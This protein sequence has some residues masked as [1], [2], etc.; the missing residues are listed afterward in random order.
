MFEKLEKLCIKL[1]G[2]CNFNC[3]Y[4]HQPLLEKIHG[5][6]NEFE[7]LEI[8]L[9]SL[10][11]YEKEIEIVCGGGEPTLVPNLIRKLKRIADRLEQSKDISVNLALVSNGSKLNVLNT[12]I[13]D[14]I[15]NPKNIG[16]SWDGNATTRK[17]DESLI[18]ELCKYKF[19]ND[20]NITYAITPLSI[21]NMVNDFLFCWDSGIKDLSYYFIHEGNYEN[22]TLQEKF[23]ENI[24]ILVEEFLDRKVYDEKLDFFN[25]SYWHYCNKINKPKMCMKLGKGFSVGLDG[26]LYPC[27]YFG[28]HHKNSIGDI[29]NGLNKELIDKFLLE[30]NQPY[31]CNWKECKNNNCQ[32]CPASN[33]V[34]NDGCSNKTLN[35]CKMHDI[36]R[37]VYSQYDYNTTFDEPM[38][39]NTSPSFLSGNY[40]ENTILTSL[41]NV[42]ESPALNVVRNWND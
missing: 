13:E 16:I 11:N 32:E 10:N 3:L 42:I 21:N 14:G 28:D 33:S 26:K 18:E 20:V 25:F 27:I 15:L 23:K 7:Q 31:T 8:F 12:L 40:V 4:C 34:H 1:N 5:D 29:Y 37:E 24:K 19:Y 38:F 35:I 2:R 39:L 9:Q 41:D 17:S 36:E 30:Y 22:I 6:F